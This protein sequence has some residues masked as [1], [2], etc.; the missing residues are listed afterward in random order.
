[1]INHNSKQKYSYKE[2]INIEFLIS[3]CAVLLSFLEVEVEDAVN[4]LA[5]LCLTRQT[6]YPVIYCGKEDSQKAGSDGLRICE[7]SVMEYRTFCSILVGI[8]NHTV[9]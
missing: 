5:N 6:T 4:E 7:P 3:G 8:S 2:K 1:M 9:Y